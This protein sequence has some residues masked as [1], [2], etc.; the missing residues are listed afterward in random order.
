M[1]AASF[2]NAKAVSSNARKTIKMIYLKKRAASWVASMKNIRTIIKLKVARLIIFGCSLLLIAAAGLY[3]GKKILS[4]KSTPSEKQTQILPTDKLYQQARQFFPEGEVREITPVYNEKEKQIAW[5]G[6]VHDKNGGCLGEVNQVFENTSFGNGYHLLDGEVRTE[7]SPTTKAFVELLLAKNYPNSHIKEILFIA[8]EPGPY[9]KTKIKL[10][11]GSVR[12]DQ[13]SPHRYY[14]LTQCEKTTKKDTCYLEVGS[15]TKDAG[16]C[17]KI[18]EEYKRNNCYALTF[19]LRA[20]DK[21]NSSICD[22]FYDQEAHNGCIKFFETLSYETPCDSCPQLAPPHPN[23]C[24]NGR[25]TAREKVVNYA[26]NCYC[27][28][29]PKCL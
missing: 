11:D 24:E 27:F 17:K 1:T 16:V 22:D 23:W 26:K 29:P 8:A 19:G 7:C 20:P 28:G 14:E 21:W 2:K 3:A 4:P 25:E 18:G 15:Y 10:A 12:S 6:I 9:W 13:F 5:I